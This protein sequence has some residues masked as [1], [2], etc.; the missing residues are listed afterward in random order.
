VRIMV[1]GKNENRHGGKNPEQL[2]DA[3]HERIVHL[4]VLEKI[5]PPE[6]R[7]RPPF[8]RQL[9]RP[10]QRI[11]PRLTQS[12]PARAELREPR[13]QLPIRGMDEPK[14]RQ[15]RMA[16]KM[17]TERKKENRNGSRGP[18]ITRRR[19]SPLSIAGLCF[20]GA[21]SLIPRMKHRFP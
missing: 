6:G 9:E 3:G 15:K 16:Q 10:P 11:P 19:S 14:H 12:G 8:A 7:G 21:S 13:A 1:P 5:S 4:V 20:A 17:P 18:G 2:D